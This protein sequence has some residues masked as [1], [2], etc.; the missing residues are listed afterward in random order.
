MSIPGMLNSEGKRSLWIMNSRWC[1]PS[2]YLFLC[3]LVF[4][5][6]FY[7]FFISSSILFPPIPFLLKLFLILT[8]ASVPFLVNSFPIFFSP[9]IPFH[10]SLFNKYC[11]HCHYAIISPPSVS[12][13]ATISTDWKRYFLITVLALFFWI[14]YQLLKERQSNNGQKLERS[15]FNFFMEQLLIFFL[16]AFVTLNLQCWFSYWNYWTDG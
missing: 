1:S 7:S 13:T 15:I 16:R 2:F 12:L 14:N 6:S 3:E 10:V 4:D 9:S 5:F 11:E 8:T